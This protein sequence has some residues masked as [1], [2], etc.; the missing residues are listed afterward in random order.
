MLPRVSAIIPCHDAEATVARALASVQAQTLDDWEAIVIDDASRDGTDK[1]VAPFLRDPRIRYIRQPRN[2]GAGPARNAGLDVARGRWV[3]FLDADD[4]WHPPKLAR[5]TAFLEAER[6]QIGATA[7]ARR[8]GGT[9]RDLHFGLPRRI[10]YR[11][12]L[13]TNVMGFSTVMIDRAWLGAQRMPQLRRR[14]D[15]AFL[16]ALLRAGGVAVG[17]NEVLCTYH[18]G[19]A[20]LS[21]AKGRAA[22]DTWALYRD[23]LGLSGAEAAWYF[24]HYALRGAMRHKAPGLARRLGVLHRPDDAPDD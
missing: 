4:E 17:L 5:Q 1:A 7:Y 2:E 20:S 6:A 3:A 9:G 21:S 22:R 15:F 23:H 10:R 24:G 16:I 11:D 12:F 19:H 13:K 14:Q 8:H 18:H